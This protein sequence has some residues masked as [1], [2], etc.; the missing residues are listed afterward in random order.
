MPVLSRLCR[1]AGR[2]NLP[3]FPAGKCC[4]WR[5]PAASTVSASFA[6]HVKYTYVLYFVNSCYINDLWTVR[7]T[8][9]TRGNVRANFS[10]NS[11]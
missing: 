7:H 6:E 10:T 1:S 5:Y 2:A 8:L 3:L 9:D 11:R 4:D